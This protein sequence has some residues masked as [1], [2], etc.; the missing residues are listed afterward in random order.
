MT[1]HA[2]KFCSGVA[3]SFCL[4]THKK[5]GREPLEGSG[6]TFFF[7]GSEMRFPKFSRGKSHKSIQSMKKL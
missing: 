4:G 3:W 2:T 6:K 1:G 7:R 5:E